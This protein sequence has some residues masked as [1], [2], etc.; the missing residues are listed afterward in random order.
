MNRAVRHSPEA[1]AILVL[2]PDAMLDPEAVPRMLRRAAQAGGRHRR[3]PHAGGRTGSLSPTLRRGPTLG[4]VG[5]LSFTGLAAFTERIEDPREY[6]HRARGR[7]GGRRDPARRRR[8]LRR[9]RRP[10]RVV[11]PL[12]GGDGLQP[13]RPGRR[14]GDGLH[15]GGRRDAHRRRVGRERDDPHD[16]DREPRPPLPPA[17]RAPPAWVYFA[18]TVLIEMRRAVLGPPRV[19]AHAS[20]PCCAPRD[21]R[22]CSARAT[23]CLP[24][25]APSGRRKKVLLIAPACDGED[26]GESWVAHQWAKHAVASGTT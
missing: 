16:E 13:A 18:L 25:D 10:G 4:R 24:S 15:A 2:N 17:A 12:L 20:A 11:L 19:L 8:V 14:L 23:L 3:A 7:L 9:A 26:V 1:A 6:D 21:G 22:P 5:G